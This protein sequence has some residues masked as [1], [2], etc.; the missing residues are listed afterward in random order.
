MSK[1]K[2]AI[3][4]NRYADAQRYLLMSGDISGFARHPQRRRLLKTIPQFL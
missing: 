2:M 1:A 3:E 4:E